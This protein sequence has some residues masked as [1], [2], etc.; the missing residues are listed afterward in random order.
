MSHAAAATNGILGGWQLSGTM[1]FYSGAPF[2]VEDSTINANI[3]ESTRPNRIA[4]AKDVSGTGRRGVD[5]PWF[6]PDA[7]VDAPA[8]ISRTN[9]SPDKYGF[10]PFQPGNSGRNILDGPGVQ[11][12]NLSLLKRFRLA[13]RKSFQFRWETFNI[14]NHPNFKLPDHN[15]NETAAGFV[16]DV[17]ASGQGGPRVM[18]FSLRYEF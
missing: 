6:D 16:N 8:C 2:T 3:G 15:F 5:Y 18:Q 7:F 4:T 12:I 1:A 14:F 11:N 9:C 17:A 10:I 13:E